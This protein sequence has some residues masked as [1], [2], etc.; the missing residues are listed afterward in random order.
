MQNIKTEV[1]REKKGFWKSIGGQIL[2]WILFLPLAT[3]GSHL[4]GSLS[5][6]VFGFC[7]SWIS[8]P[9]PTSLDFLDKFFVGTMSNMLSGASWVFIGAYIA[10][11]HKKIVAVIIAGYGLVWTGA[12]LVLIALTETWSLL[13][14]YE[15]IIINV[16]SIGMATC[17]LKDEIKVLI[18]S[19][20]KDSC[21]N[22]KEKEQI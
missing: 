7:L 4:C 21:E 14:L 12:G 11:S 22:V 18:V 19:K 5:E 16:G 6:L 1:V 17:I 13:L 2:R 8:G 10:P 3:L 15:I 9:W 20:K